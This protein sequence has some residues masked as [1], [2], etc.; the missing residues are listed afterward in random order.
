MLIFALGCSSQPITP[1]SAENTEAEL[2]KAA[3]P[4]KQTTVYN[5]PAASESKKAPTQETMEEMAPP[6]ASCETPLGRIP[7]GGKATGYL[8]ATVPADEVCISDT[9]S[10]RDGKWTGDAIHPT[11]KVIKEKSK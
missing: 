3:P 8:Q 7:D 10:C 11:C 1:D 4:P 2:A 5:S 9:I 6:R